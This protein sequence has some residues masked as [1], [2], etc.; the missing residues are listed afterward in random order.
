MKAGPLA[1][2][3]SQIRNYLRQNKALLHTEA[4]I[5]ASSDVRQVFSQLDAGT[6]T[7][8]TTYTEDAVRITPS[9]ATGISHTTGTDDI[10]D[11]DSSAPFPLLVWELD[12]S[13]YGPDLRL[14]KVQ[15]YLDPQRNTANPP[16]DGRFVLE[17]LALKEITSGDGDPEIWKMAEVASSIIVPASSIT[18][19][20]LVDFTFASSYFGN[21]PAP[22]IINGNFVATLSNVHAPAAPIL[23]SSTAGGRYV[24]LRLRAFPG[25]SA[26]TNY[27]WKYNSAT[28][29]PETVAN[30]GKLFYVSGARP[31]D[32]KYNASGDNLKVTLGTGIPRATFTVNSYGATGT[33]AFTGG[34]QMDL[35]ASVTGTVE[36]RVLDEVPQ[37]CTGT[38]YA[39][40]NSGDAWVAVKDGQTS[41]DVG[42]ASSQ[43]YEMKYEFA[44]D[45]TGSASPT[46]R[47]L[48]IVD[49]T[50]V[51]LTEIA[52]WSGQPQCAVSTAHCG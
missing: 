3:N 21:T 27:S 12:E 44:S 50:L 11:L 19:A 51:D 16:F 4:I 13:V 32:N 2:D 8:V 10:T 23:A 7:T 40:V 28:S 24:V 34:S 35:G 33:L 20:G 22:V 18:A 41:T 15:V 1:V 17:V 45:S 37:G 14:S 36:F 48:G 6:K 30:K 5:Q 47:R 38:A 31:H 42:L 26:N 49:R 43:T 29:N 25:P 52:N 9:N 46:L 39:R